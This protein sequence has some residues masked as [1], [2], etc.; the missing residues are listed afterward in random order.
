MRFNLAKRGSI[1]A[2]EYARGKKKKEKIKSLT[3]ELVDK[4][5]A[6]DFEFTS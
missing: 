2:F 5:M 1:R 3:L 4:S 6:N